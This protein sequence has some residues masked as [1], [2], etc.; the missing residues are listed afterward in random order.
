MS[1]STPLMDVIKERAEKNP[2]FTGVLNILS[3]I[4]IPV[5]VLFRKDFGERYFTPM[6][7]LTG[8]GL[9]TW[10]VIIQRSMFELRDTF[11]P[12]RTSIF[13]NS[14][15]QQ[16][17]QEVVETPLLERFM[18]HTMELVLIA[19][20]VLSAFHFFKI[21]WRNRTNTPLHSRADGVSRLEPLAVGLMDLTNMALAPITRFFMRLFLSKEEEQKIGKIPPHLT[22]VSV[23]TDTI[24]EPLVMV[25]LSFLFRYFGDGTTSAWLLWS[26]AAVYFFANLKQDARLHQW[27]DMRDRSIEAKIR[28]EDRDYFKVINRDP[29]AEIEA[30]KI[31]SKQQMIMEQIAENVK[32][33]PAI[34]EEMKL[35]YPDLMDIIEEMN[36]PPKG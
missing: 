13:G 33:I 2:I 14:Y 4:S 30:P 19:Y 12:Q 20:L 27:L 9:L 23:F 7:F 26:G 34:A 5:S 10:L 29:K 24:F 8:A 35:E 31:S 3:W 6:S 15:P 21:W 16:T 18:S 22:D 25:L 11:Q 32:E 17:P 36:T 1:G 28:S